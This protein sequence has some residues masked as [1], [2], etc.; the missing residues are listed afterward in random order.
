MQFILIGSND[1]RKFS[2]SRLHSE[3]VNVPLDE[4]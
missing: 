1:Q 2:L 3:S 4:H